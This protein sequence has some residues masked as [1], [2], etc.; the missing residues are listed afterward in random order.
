MAANDPR[1]TGDDNTGLHY[2]DTTSG[3]IRS[4]IAQPRYE[5]SVPDA[6]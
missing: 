2:Y 6:W 5:P 3:H 4:P 1:P